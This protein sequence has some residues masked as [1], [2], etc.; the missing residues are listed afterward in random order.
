MNKRVLLLL[1][2]FIL[3]GCN[4][5]EDDIQ[6]NEEK[7]EI[8]YIPNNTGKLSISMRP[9][10]TLN[11]LINQDVTVDN[12]L[13]LI[14]EPLFTLDNKLKPIPNLASSIEYLDNGRSAIIHLNQGISWSD[15]TSLSAEDVIFSL[16]V[17]KSASGSAIYKEI[18]SNISGY[19]AIDNSTVKI[20][21][22]NSNG[23]L[24]YELCFPIIPEHYY[25]NG[26]SLNS[27]QNMKPIG[28]GPFE[29]QN[30]VTVKEMNLTTNSSYF[31]N[32]PSIKDI[33]VIISSD[34]ET[35]FYSFDQ[36]IT[37]AL[38]ESLTDW[39]KFGGSRKVSYN[40]VLTNYFDF[41]GFNFRNY[42]LQDVKVREAIAISLNKEK[43]VNDAYL[44]QG[45]ITESFI[46]PKSW[47]YN[48]ELVE[49]N[50]NL[51]QARQLFLQ[52]NYKFNDQTKKLQKVVSGVA[53][54]LKFK[55]IV[56]E[57]NSERV[58]IAHVLKT[59][60]ESIG[61]TIDL[62][63]VDF[64]TY[65][66]ML[67]SHDFDLFLGGVNFSNYPDFDFLL[68]SSNGNN[69]FYYSNNYVDELLSNL[70][71]SAN[72]EEYLVNLN[73]LQQ[74]V[75][76]DIPFISIAFRQNILLLDP[77]IKGD[78]SPRKNNIYY[79]INNWTY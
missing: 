66:R 11:P 27:T 31:K 40:S 61:I 6:I 75:L 41:I 58:K 46:N 17:I 13:K 29:F 65:S 68:G 72:S 57:E 22:Y 4:N 59:N 77:S 24:G 18:V 48:K 53:T 39:G 33:N 52:S 26:L 5:R 14:F 1:L 38:E 54:D 8:T 3:V 2:I 62:V 34:D 73:Q 37:G 45:L 25:K 43:L 35:D 12:V 69:Y 56:N 71:H 7:N 32:Q 50:Y 44:G 55:V 67:Q 64:D 23:A 60:L 79:G 51:K 74:A 78:I 16:N 30:Y 20:N 15:G 19:S 47:L 9:P 10:K 28:N 70:K 76:D 63:V 36:G 21:F 49:Y 42:I